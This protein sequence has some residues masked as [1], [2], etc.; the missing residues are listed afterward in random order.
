[1][2][3][4]LACPQRDGAGV[5]VKRKAK[6]WKATHQPVTQEFLNDRAA[7][8]LAAG[9]SVQ[10]WI[11]FCSRLLALGFDVSLYEARQTFSKYV[12]VSD[13][14]KRFKV[15]FSNHRPIKRREEMGDCDFF[16]G[17]ANYQTTTT[18][19]ALAAT[20]KHFGRQEEDARF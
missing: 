15:R 3:A 17:V 16:V 12:T 18:A 1:M 14:Q 19:Q 6:P 4:D 2:G 5:M 13:G 8:S 11:A 9:Y 7:R 10:K 20:L